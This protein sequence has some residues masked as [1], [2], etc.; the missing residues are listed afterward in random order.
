MFRRLLHR[1]IALMVVVV[2]AG[3]AIAGFLVMGLVVR[4]QVR[5]VAS[6]T[7]DMISA[8]SEAMAKLPPRERDALLARINAAGNMGVRPA[9]DVPADGPRF[10]TLVERQ[11]TRILAERLT[12][13]DHLVWRTDHEGRL[14]FMLRMGG[15]DYWVS[16]TSPRQGGAITSLIVALLVAFVVSVACG[17]ALQRRIDQP[18]RRLTRSLEDFRTDGTQ[19]PVSASGPEEVAALATALNRMNRRIADQEADRALMLAGVSHDLRTPLTKLRL[20]LALMHGEDEELEAG[21]LRQVDRIEAM[22]AQFLEYARGFEAE[23]PQSVAVR[24]MLCAV[25][26]EAAQTADRVRIDASPT[27]QAVLRPQAVSRAIDNLLGNAMR[28][29]VPPVTLT[30]TREGRMVRIRVRDCGDGF[31]PDMA[32]SIMRPFAR[33]DSARGGEG[34][35]LG[36]A[37]VHRVAMAHAGQLSFARVEGGFEARLDLTDGEGGAGVSAG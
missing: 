14:W 13:Q 20:S 30:A 36:L 15:G 34:T 3:Q 26:G 22:L 31:A 11:F 16:V 6:V 8:M 27:L 35:G 18:L 17:M 2:L 37:I 7:A 4:P 23:E 24:D 9:S 5:R 21:A 1:N 28:H 12:A 10:P 25:A 32:E 19:P 33:G 29:G